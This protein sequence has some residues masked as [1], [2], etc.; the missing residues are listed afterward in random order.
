MTF[1]DNANQDV[2]IV[3]EI[4]SYDER[5]EVE[6]ED[7]TELS[8]GNDAENCRSSSSSVFN[9]RIMMILI[10]AV[11]ILLFCVAGFSAAVVSQNNADANFNS[12]SKAPKPKAS[13]APNASKAPKASS[14]PGP[15][16]RR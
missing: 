3:A 15:S 12:A 6:L 13:K 10:V 14:S 7:V 8:F 5:L 9:K 2:E 11:A 1:I 16:S 4:P